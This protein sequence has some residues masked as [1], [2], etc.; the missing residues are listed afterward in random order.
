MKASQEQLRDYQWIETTT[1]AVNGEQQSQVQK[2][3]YYGV[4]GKLEKVIENQTPDG[5]IYAE[6]LVLAAS[7]ENL[8]VTVENAGYQRVAG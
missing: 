7:S 1:V 5:T 6:K 2:R 8:T 4:D 3:C